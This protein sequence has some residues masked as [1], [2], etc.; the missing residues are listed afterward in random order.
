MLNQRNAG[1]T[2]I[3]LMMVIVILGILAAIA[4]PSFQAILEA[5]RL[6]GASDN[7][8][9]LLSYAKSEAIKKNQTIRFQVSVDGTS[10]CIG[11]DDDAGEVCDCT[12]N[13]CEVDAVAKNVTS[14][15]FTGVQM[16]ASAVVEFNG[17]GMP[18]IVQDYTNSVQGS[19]GNTKSVVV[20]GV[21][22]ISVN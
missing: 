15:L 6:N 8:Y 18:T 16:T 12:T 11:I 4:L 14:T 9:A 17:K 1:F 13:A 19:S 21:G 7:L 2:L 20:N 5:R 3:E 22:R 10:W